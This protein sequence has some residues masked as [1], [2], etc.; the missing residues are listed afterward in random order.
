MADYRGGPDAAARIREIERTRE[1]ERKRIAEQKE[2]IKEE[3]KNKVMHINQKF[4]SDSSGISEKLVQETVG[5][6][7]VEEFKKK[8][9]RLE[10]DERRKKAVEEIEQAKKQERKKPR[11]QKGKLSF[12]IED[13]EDGDEGESKTEGG[14]SSTS[15]T[16]TSTEDDNT[17]TRRTFGKD[18][19]VNTTFLPDREREI[20]E[21]EERQRLT[22]E[23][24]Q[25]QARHKAETLTVTY[26]YWDGSGHRRETTVKK[27][28]TVA[29]FLELARQEF[30]ELRGVSAENLMFV[31]EDVIIPHHLTFHDLIV[32]KARG[33]SGPLFQFD[34]HDDVR[35]LSDATQETTESHA[36]KVVERSWYNRN[37]HIF[38]ASRWEV[39]DPS[40]VIEKYTLFDKKQKE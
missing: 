13:D 15:T 35:L 11:I 26:S 22:E 27:G 8:R 6:V 5:L 4:S 12:D 36:G 18:P 9:E 28:A 3:T 39:Y 7:S 20:K 23:Y 21:R 19:K 30:R 33:K 10:A 25:E 1:N 29:Q 16:S 34:V 32:T 24:E 17:G 14:E 40:K 2:R 38:P 31:K 37:Q